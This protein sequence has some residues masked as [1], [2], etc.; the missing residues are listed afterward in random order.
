MRGHRTVRDRS[1]YSMIV[2]SAGSAR[3]F[4]A[5]YAQTTHKY[6]YLQNMCIFLR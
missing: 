3:E 4:H 6:K 5:K 2:L 1:E